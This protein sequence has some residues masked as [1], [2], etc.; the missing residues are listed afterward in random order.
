MSRNRNNFEIPEVFRKAMEDAGWDLGN[1]KEDDEGGNSGGDGGNGRNRPPFPRNPTE[2]QRPNR[3][4]WLLGLFFL[5]LLSL[6]WIVTTYTEWL[7]F[8]ELSYQN[9]WLKRWGVQVLSFVVSFALAAAVLLLNWRL[10]RRRASKSTPSH[11]PQF[12]Q[13]SGFNW[14][15]NG[16]G[17]FFAFVF[18]SAAAS[19]WESILLYLNQVPFNISDPL[20][21]QDISVYLFTLPIYQFLQGWFSSLLLFTILGLL[22]IYFIR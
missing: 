12:L 7:W 13:F 22:F 20:L 21:G 15:I 4:I 8:T 16:V 5:L 19:Q 10:A 14:L 11:Y 6:N 2:P 17:L 1:N 3:I 9:V 18:A